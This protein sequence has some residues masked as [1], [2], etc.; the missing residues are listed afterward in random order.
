[1]FEVELIQ[2]QKLSPV[3]FVF[4]GRPSGEFCLQNI[5][6]GFY[7]DKELFTILRAGILD[8]FG[9]TTSQKM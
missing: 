7:T 5:S 4:L 9:E 2:T 8:A 1:L 6:I 3:N